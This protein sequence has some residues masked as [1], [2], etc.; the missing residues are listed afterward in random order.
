MKKSTEIKRYE[1]LKEKI[2]HCKLQYSNEKHT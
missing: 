2:I 1:N